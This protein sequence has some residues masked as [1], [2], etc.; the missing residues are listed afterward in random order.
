MNYKKFFITGGAGFIGSNLCSKL[1]CDTDSLI[2][3]YDNFSNGKMT[4][5][6]ELDGK[7]RLKI[8]KADVL[9]TKTLRKSMAG[10]DM[11]IHLAANADIALSASSTELDLNQTVIATYNVL[12]AMRINN[13]KSIVYSS[14]SGVYGDLGEISPAESFGPLYPVSLYGAT[15]L[16][17]EA[18]ISAF[19]S[20]FEMKAF[21]FRFANVVGKNQ[22]H[23]VA[24]DFINK[25]LANNKELHVLGN[26]LQSKSYIHVNDIIAAILTSIEK[27]SAIIDTYNVGTG[28]YISVKEIASIVIESMKLDSVTVSF[29]ETS[30][31][32]KGDVPKVRFTSEKICNLG[33]T[34]QFGSRQA[35]KFSVSQMLESKKPR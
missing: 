26:G 10:S 15:K 1:L 21:I 24:Y 30:I 7:G 18:L 9:D 22:T 25:L 11:V 19:S 20:L 32:W 5:L 28:D 33:W 17:A 4:F 6:E 35:I 2:T 27:Q 34:P 12:E 16:S 31:G 14:G 23:G 29:G 3:I 8:I 13:I